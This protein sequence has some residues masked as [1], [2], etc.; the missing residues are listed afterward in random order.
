MFRTGHCSW[1]DVI[2][3]TK[4]SNVL[5]ICYDNYQIQPRVLRTIRALEPAYSVSVAGYSSAKEHRLN[6]IDLSGNVR[7]QSNDYW[8]FNKPFFIRLPVS[9]YHRFIKQKQ[10]YKPW[11]FEEMYWDDVRRKDLKELKKSNYDLII[12]HGIDSLP[13][14]IRLSN[15]SVPV[16]F[17]A[18]EYYPL[19][20][21]NDQVWLKT[22]GPKASY[23]VRNYLPKC[24]HMFCV[25]EEIQKKYQ[26]EVKIASTVITNA[27]EFKSLEPIATSGKVKILHH[28]AAIRAREIEIMADMISLLDPR[29]ELSLMLVPTDQNYY[30]ELKI[31]YRGNARIRFIDPV[32]TVEIAEECNKH[33]IGL[34]ILPPVNFNW[35]NAL[36]NKLFEFVQGRLCL[37]VSPN[38]D[39]KKLVEANNIGIVSTDYTA[40]SM[41]DKI[42]ALK[43]EDIDKY[44]FNAHK[45]AL[46]LSGESNC[47][48]MRNV[49]NKLVREK[50]A[51]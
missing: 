6:F 9:F 3:K 47:E 31:K 29:F 28:G 5:I 40:A 20:F 1:W 19:E 7:K 49:I 44:K 46:K 32:P 38:P 48:L 37:A 45:A 16:I 8:H 10:F 13:L 42:N 33:D 18:H 17:N 35:L 14:A 23:F 24:A 21:E 50:C 2:S 25:S 4:M 15:H 36:P 26:E 43:K 22:Q 11:Y 39:M 51:A 34:F 30:N 12:C 41:A 27:T